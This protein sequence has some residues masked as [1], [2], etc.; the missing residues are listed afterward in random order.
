MPSGPQH[1]HLDRAVGPA[2][3]ELV[4]VVVAAAVDVGD[5]AGPD[6]PTLLEHRPPVG[7]LAGAS[8]VVGARKRRDRKSVL[9]GRGVSARDTIGGRRLITIKKIPSRNIHFP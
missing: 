8:Y 7:D 3:D 9:S 2:M 6:D 5:R 1:G 4:D